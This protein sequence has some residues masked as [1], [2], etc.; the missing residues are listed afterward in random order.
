M[1]NVKKTDSP[2]A[3]LVEADL[4]LE[5][6]L[7]TL[8][9]DVPEYAGPEPRAEVAAPPDASART[10]E[11]APPSIEPQ[12]VVGEIPADALNNASAEPI[13]EQDD[14]VEAPRPEWADGDFKAL[15]VR[16]GSLRFAVPLVCLN[17]IALLGDD[18]ALAAIPGQPE[19]HLGVMRYREQKLVVVDP[20]RLLRL[21]AG[22]G[23]GS[24][25]L[26]IGEGRYGLVCGAIEEQLTL[27]ADKVNWRLAA[28][29]RD[30]MLGILPE[31]M[32]VLLDT[33]LIAR[34]LQAT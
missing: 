18:Q 7:G 20:A 15:V 31:Q 11:T 21:Q 30:W 6:L 27:R 19:W 3:Q 29:R 25:L 13:Q 8:L 33:D 10:I 12:P 23:S 24:H 16:L 22:E 32:C 4:A 17:S 2:S 28:D 26:V 34:R 9:E 1:A 14:S 5:D